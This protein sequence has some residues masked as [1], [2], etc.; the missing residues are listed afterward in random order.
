MELIFT[1]IDLKITQI[2]TSDLQ[3][4]KSVDYKLL[5]SRLIVML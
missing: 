5:F 2:E 3:K 1:F 4:I